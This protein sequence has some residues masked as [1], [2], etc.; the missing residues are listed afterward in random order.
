MR[1]AHMSG[2]F[3]AAVAAHHGLLVGQAD[4]ARWL[5]EAMQWGR[6]ADAQRMEMAVS[7]VLFC[8]VGS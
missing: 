5:L 1:Y 7:D 2:N 3:L 4:V 8:C 6:A